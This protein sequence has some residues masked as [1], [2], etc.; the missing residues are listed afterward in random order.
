MHLCV[1]CKYSVSE[2]YFFLHCSIRSFLLV[3]W[4][5]HSCMRFIRMIII[6]TSVR[7]LLNWKLYKVLYSLD[8]N[9]NCRVI[10]ENKFSIRFDKKVGATQVRNMYQ[11][12]RMIACIYALQLCVGKKTECF[13]FRLCMRRKRENIELKLFVFLPFD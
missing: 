5:I 13:V 11:S 6:R 3:S 7:N 9:L 8:V 12:V 10:S 2:C 1:Q 4:L